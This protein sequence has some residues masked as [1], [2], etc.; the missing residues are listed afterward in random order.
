[1][2][3]NEMFLLTAA[4]VC[5]LASAAASAEFPQPR[6]GQTAPK[7]TLKGLYGRP[8]ALT[9]YKGKL[10]VVHFGAGW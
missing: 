2:R 9:D 5:G 1:M 3:S 8:V 7:F 10:V 4:L 6:L